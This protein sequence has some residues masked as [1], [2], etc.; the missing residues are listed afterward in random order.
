M[1]VAVNMEEISLHD[2]EVCEHCG[3]LEPSIQ[4]CPSRYPQTS[5]EKDMLREKITKE[6]RI[7]SPAV[8]HFSS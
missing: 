2:R 1:E 3:D 5:E 6:L 4:V 7:S 8:I